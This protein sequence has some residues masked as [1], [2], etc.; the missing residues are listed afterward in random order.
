MTR[1]TGF[2]PQG[3][4]QPINSRINAVIELDNGVVGPEP[5]A[6]FLPKDH[7]TGPFHQHGQDLDG[8]LG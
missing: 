1:H 8:L 5:F 4:S 2:V 6:D 3:T 7:F